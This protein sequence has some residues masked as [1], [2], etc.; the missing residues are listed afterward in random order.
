MILRNRRIST[1]LPEAGV[2]GNGG[3]ASTIPAP[4][5][6]LKTQP[7]VQVQQPASSFSAWLQYLYF[8]RMPI[9]GWLPPNP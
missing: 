2:Y 4:P 9:A 6:P 8:L 7:V 5:E 1:Y 3:G